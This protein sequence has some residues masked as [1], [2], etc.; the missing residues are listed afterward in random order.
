MSDGLRKDFSTQASEKMTPDSSKTTT[1]KIGENLT[2]AGDKVASAVQPSSEKSTTQKAGDSIRGE[3]DSAQK[4]GGGIVDK[5]TN[6][7]TD[8]V[9][10]LT[11]KTEETA[12]KNDL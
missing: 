4:Q 11:G 10:S 6:T 1:E 12:K 3:G 7:V 9:N 5:V 2:G 8:T